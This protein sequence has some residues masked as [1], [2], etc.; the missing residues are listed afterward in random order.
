MDFGIMT[1]FLIV[2]RKQQRDSGLL[3]MTLPSVNSVSQFFSNLFCGIAFKNETTAMLF[4]VKSM[5]SLFL[6]VTKAIILNTIKE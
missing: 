6:Q 1:F 4:L 5:Y 3:I 2:G